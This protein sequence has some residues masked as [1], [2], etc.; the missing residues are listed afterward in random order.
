MNHQDTNLFVRFDTALLRKF[1]S[2]L[3]E[4]LH[5]EMTS[6][7]DDDDDDDDDDVDDDNDDEASTSLCCSTRRFESSTA[8][9][10]KG[11]TRR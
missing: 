6:A 8:C 9:S 3:R 1:D 10:G 2:M 5:K 11:G 4:G 7:G